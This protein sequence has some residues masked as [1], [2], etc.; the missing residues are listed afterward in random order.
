MRE[1]NVPFQG[2]GSLIIHANLWTPCHGNCGQLLSLNDARVCAI[3]ICGTCRK[4]PKKWAAVRVETRK[5][6]RAHTTHE[7]QTNPWYPF[8]DFHAAW[9]AS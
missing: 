6:M 4:D 9:S 5:H 2:A 8:P 3:L 1:I 7:R